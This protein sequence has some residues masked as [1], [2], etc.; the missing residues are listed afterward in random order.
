MGIKSKAVGSKLKTGGIDDNEMKE[1]VN[2]NR[3]RLVIGEEE[4]SS[5]MNLAKS[6]QRMDR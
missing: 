2:E 4:T 6:N 3:T 1:Y 5:Y